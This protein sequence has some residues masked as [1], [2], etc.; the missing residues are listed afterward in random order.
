MRVVVLYGEG[1]SFCAGADLDWMQRMADYG[2]A[3]NVADADALARMLQTLYRLSKP[4]LACVQGAAYGGGV[5]LIACCD[6]A[7][8]RQPRRSRCRRRSWG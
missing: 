3:E 2:Y 8:A 4:T 5:G 1:R 6:I 7:F